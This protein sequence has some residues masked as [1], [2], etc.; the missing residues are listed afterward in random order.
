MKNAL[1]I[2]KIIQ[3]FKKK[4]E[5]EGDKSISIRWALL[6]SQAL[7]KSRSYNLLNSEDVISTLNCL[8]KLGIKVK[9]SKKSCEIT[10]NGLNG[11]DYKKNISPK[12]SV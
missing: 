3:P 12:S 5:I 8:R 9:F 1:K 10:G 4:I 11:F 2:S 7:G 6:A